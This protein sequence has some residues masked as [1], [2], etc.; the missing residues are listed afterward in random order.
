MG[1]M[2]SKQLAERII[3]A[4]GQ[5][6][7]DERIDGVLLQ[8]ETFKEQ[9]AGLEIPAPLRQLI[10]SQAGRKRHE[11]GEEK[12]IQH[13][14]FQTLWAAPAPKLHPAVGRALYNGHNDP[15]SLF[16]G[17]SK[18]LCRES[19]PADYLN[20]LYELDQ[21]RQVNGVRWRLSLIP[22]LELFNKFG[23]PHA[24]TETYD[25]LFR[26]ISESSLRFQHRDK[27]RKCLPGWVSKS[28]R[29]N[30][31][32]EELGIGSLCVLPDIGDSLWET[33]LPMEGPVHAAC[34]ALLLDRG[35]KQAASATVDDRGSITVGTATETV[36]GYMR[37]LLDKIPF[38]YQGLQF[39]SPVRQG[40]VRRRRKR[41]EFGP[42]ET[43]RRRASFQ[44]CANEQTT[45]PRQ[46]KTTQQ[47]QKRRRLHAILSNQQ[48]A[49]S[50]DGLI[51][52]SHDVQSWTEGGHGS[53][54][55]NIYPEVLT[56]RNPDDFAR[57]P[58]EQATTANQ[59]VNQE[60]QQPQSHAMDQEIENSTQNLDLLARAA[61]DSNAPTNSEISS[62]FTEEVAAT[63]SEWTSMGPEVVTDGELEANSLSGLQLQHFQSLSAHPNGQ[64]SGYITHGNVP[65]QSPQI[66]DL[67]TWANTDDAGIVP[68]SNTQTTDILVFP[69]YG[70]PLSWGG[71][72]DEGS[73]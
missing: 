45:R 39:G 46:D 10:S 53:D 13:R 42:N 34:T 11:Y 7:G 23:N 58:S 47:T 70:H 28:K 64:N 33:H 16:R 61:A 65:A 29:Y 12:I 55:A 17:V 21:S 3:I 50:Q 57:A 60:V 15:S 6:N 36:I 8:D 37:S 48:S 19:S 44:A 18:N 35:I 40:E 73:F 4:C 43:F 67:T 5:V 72:V 14:A 22:I 32:V 9:L 59:P 52:R 27:I 66:G 38:L 24:N 54:L 2:G 31:L 68:I 20:Y 26:L 49:R 69:P 56:N 51:H 41:S 30:T 62:G 1:A 25:H 63:P 71:M